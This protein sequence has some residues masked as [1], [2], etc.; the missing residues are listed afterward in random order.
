MSIIDIK[1]NKKLV[2]SNEQFTENSTL[3]EQTY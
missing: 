1:L 2:K 3:N